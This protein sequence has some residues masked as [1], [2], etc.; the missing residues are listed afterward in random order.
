MYKLLLSVLVISA[1]LALTGCKPEPT[2]R[3][4]SADF[5]ETWEAAVIV[6]RNLTSA[7]PVQMDRERG[8]IATR[9]TPILGP[10]EQPDPNLGEI[11]VYQGVIDL[12]PTPQGTKVTVRVEQQTRQRMDLISQNASGGSVTVPVDPDATPLQELFLTELA[13]RLE[14]PDEEPVFCALIRPC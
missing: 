5:D 3:T 2:S 7:E 6:V 9:W 11:D 10:S 14:Q 13:T 12:T 8:R 1:V 4:Y